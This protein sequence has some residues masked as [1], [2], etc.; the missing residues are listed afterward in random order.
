MV[1]S[2]VVFITVAFIYMLGISPDMTWMGLAG[3]SPNYVVSSIL[4]EE[5]HL[6]GYPLYI[7]IGHLFTL[8][9]F[10][11]YFSMGLFSAIST[12]LSSILI[13]LIIEHFGGRVY[14]CLLGMLVYLASFVVWTQSVIPEVYTFSVFLTLLGFYLYLLYDSTENP[15]WLAV[16][17][18]I[19]GLSLSTHPLA[20]LGV[21]GIVF[22]HWKKH[23]VLKSLGILS[24][25][26]FIGILSN[27]IFSLVL[28]DGSI[29]Q[30]HNR[31]EVL[32]V[33]LAYLGTLPIVPITATFDRIR[34]LAVVLSVSGLVFL[35]FLWGLVK[36]FNFK[37]GIIC[38]ILIIPLLVYLTGFPPQWV[39]YLVPSVAFFAILVGVGSIAF[40]SYKIIIGCVLAVILTAYNFSVYDI[41]RSIDPEPT[42]M[43]VFYNELDTLPSGTIVYTHTWGH[44]AVVVN[45]Y[46]RMN[47]FRLKHFDSGMRFGKISHFSGD[48]FIPEVEKVT[49]GEEGEI[50][51][52]VRD[53]N[54]SPVVVVYVKDYRKLK[55]SV[56]DSG[57]Y[58]NTSNNL[59][60]GQ[61]DISR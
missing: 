16:S 44:G 45:S 31:L 50:A 38:L 30:D 12:L 61:A 5:A 10:N 8:L 1:L 59:G 22:L 36:T 17:V 14:S 53:L 40:P 9:P 58:N 51:R 48:L 54:N 6:V 35:P 49:F 20:I 28:S 2:G 18:I 37:I 7:L 46:N 11:P 57:S 26:V 15:R 21:I 24:I 43:R 3:D 32:L 13:Y 25:V 34:D 29:L 19:V 41:G 56:I 23:K 27:F 60:R 42:S 47:G 39:T 4:L 55:F 33:S 52:L